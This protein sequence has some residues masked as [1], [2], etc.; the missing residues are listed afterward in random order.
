MRDDLQASIVLASELSVAVTSKRENVSGKW[1]FSK[2]SIHTSEE[3]TLFT[4][5]KQNRCF[6]DCLM[7]K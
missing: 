6:V 3:V 5:N 7:N 1:R 2:N 4:A